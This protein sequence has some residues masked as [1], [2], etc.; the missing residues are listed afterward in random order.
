MTDPTML[1]E[2]LRLLSLDGMAE[3]LGDVLALPIQ[4]RPSLEQVVSKMIDTETRHRDDRR[5]MRLLKTSKMRM[6]DVLIEDIVCS[7]ARNLTKEQLE[8]VA[9][10]NFVRRGQGLLI[11]GQTGCGKSYL[12]FALGHQ[13]CTLGLRTLYLNMNRFTETLTKA[14]IEG[15]FNDMIDRLNKNDLLI[16]DDF[17]L[18]KMDEDTIHSLLVLLDERYDKKSTIICSQLPVGKWYDY[19]AEPTHADAIMDR[20]VNSSNL[21]NLEGDSMRKR[22]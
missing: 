9:D 22:K 21:I 4:M 6:T 20:L 13:A 16:L 18:Q 15:S 12:A 2:R 11:T 10:C 5:T 17:G 19:I 7:T 8:S 14:K 3:A 1:T